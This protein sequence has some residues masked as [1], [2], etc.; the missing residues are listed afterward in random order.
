MICLKRRTTFPSSAPRKL[1]YKLNFEVYKITD[2]V[3]TN[4]FRC[5]ELRTNIQSVQSGDSLVKLRDLTEEEAIQLVSEMERTA[6]REAAFDRPSLA[7]NRRSTRAR[8]QPN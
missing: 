2:K 7:G 8:V 4:S 5:I 6:A 1:C 3:A